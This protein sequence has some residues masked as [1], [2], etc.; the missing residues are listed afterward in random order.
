[1]ASF[2]YITAV[3]SGE[4]MGIEGTGKA[5]RMRYMDFWKIQDGK[6]ADN[7]VNVDVVDVL[8]Q[9]GKDVLNGGGWEKYDEGR[10][11]PP[12]PDHQ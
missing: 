11:V 6:I 7:W 1:M 2:G 12:R 3:H 10:A 8:Q 5:V 9:L 4:F